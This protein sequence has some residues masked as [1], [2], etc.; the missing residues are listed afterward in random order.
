MTRALAVRAVLV[1]GSLALSLAVVET[2]LRLTSPL[3]P[4]GSRLALRPHVDMRLAVDLRGVPRTARHSTNAWGLRGDEPPLPGAGDYRIVAVGGSTTQCFYLDDDKTWPHL[5]QAKLT[6]AGWKVWV[7]NGGLDGHSTRGHLVFMEDV[8]SRIRPDA[9]IVLAG[10][11]DLLYSLDEQRRLQGSRYDRT[12]WLTVVYRR[13]RLA[14]VLYAWQQVFLGEALL[15]RRSGHGNFEPHL[16]GGDAAAMPGDI[17]TLL[18]GLSEYRANLERIIVLAKTTGARPVFMTQPSL[19][20]DSKY[21]QKVQGGFYWA[22]TTKTPLSAAT[23]W[24]M[25]DAYNRELLEVCSRWRV[26]CVDLAGQ[27]PHSPD[28][29]YDAVHFTEI[30]AELV[31]QRVS[32]FL[33][34]RTPR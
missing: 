19:F 5:L 17:R 29:F 9:V 4:F 26:E 15:V 8:V 13:S 22:G 3:D 12:S 16:L 31:A 11:N 30:G 7:G 34:R 25:L 18:P 6:A 32:E 24:R 21:W 14:Q 1:L 27:I 20:D 10:I 33:L 23:Y 28:Y 2:G